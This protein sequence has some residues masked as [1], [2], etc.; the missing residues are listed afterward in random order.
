MKVG[1]VS[2]LIKT[3]ILLNK[4][5]KNV[6]S[7]C[8]DGDILMLY[9][10]D[11][12]RTSAN[13]RQVLLQEVLP[14]IQ[15]IEGF[16]RGSNTSISYQDFKKAHKQLAKEVDRHR[17][18]YANPSSYAALLQKLEKFDEIALKYKGNMRLSEN[19]DNYL[20]L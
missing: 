10:N 6:A 17:R 8:E 4:W 9:E 20:L 18:A 11:F 12:S 7:L 19:L 2:P 16:A 15:D 14:K 5:D 3:S 1:E 13:S